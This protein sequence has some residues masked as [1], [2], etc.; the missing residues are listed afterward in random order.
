MSGAEDMLAVVRLNKRRCTAHGE[1]VLCRH[2]MRGGPGFSMQTHSTPLQH[3]IDKMHLLLPVS[4]EQVT[5]V[6]YVALLPK[7]IQKRGRHAFYI[8]PY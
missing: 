1:L 6:G 4:T 8:A 3:H 2:N 7:I 5:A